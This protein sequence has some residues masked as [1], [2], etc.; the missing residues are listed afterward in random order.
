MEKDLWEVCETYLTV[1]PGEPD[2][3]RETLV[4]TLD[5]LLQEYQERVA[6]GA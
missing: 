2:T 5:R 1:G 6:A 4:A 3:R